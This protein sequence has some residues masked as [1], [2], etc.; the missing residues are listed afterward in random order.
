MASQVFRAG[1]LAARAAG[2]CDN[3]FQEAGYLIVVRLPGRPTVKS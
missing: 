2:R 1:W 3:G